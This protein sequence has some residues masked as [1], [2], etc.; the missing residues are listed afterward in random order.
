MSLKR[1]LN[2]LLTFALAFMLLGVSLTPPVLYAAVRPATTHRSALHP[3]AIKAQQPQFLQPTVIPTGN[4]PAG[5]QTA[6]LNNDGRPDLVYTDYGASAT[7]SSTHILLNN[8]DGT[9]TPG[10]TIATAGASIAVAD[11]DR[12]G[13][14]DLEWVWSIQGEGR[15]YFAHGNGDGT[16]APTVLLG[17]FA[18]IGNNLPAL[19]YVTAAPMHDSGFLDLLVEDTANNT[20]FELTADSS[21]TLVRLF[22]I[23]LPDGTG[24]LTT[25]D[26]NGDGHTDLILQGTNAQGISTID[27]YLGSAD[28]IISVP[29]TRIPA[30]NGLR[31]LLLQDVDADGHPDLILESASGHLDIFHGFPDGTFSATSSGG[32]A[33]LNPA[34]GAG[35]HL[36]ALSNNHLYTATPA[37]LSALQLNPDLT[38]TLQGLYNAGPSPA[39]AHSSYVVADF[40]H[41]GTLDIALDSPDGIAILFANLDG[42]LQTSRSYSINQPALSATLGTFSGSGNT[43]AI[44]WASSKLQP[45]QTQTQLLQGS[46]D[47]TFALLASPGASIPGTPTGPILTADFNA[48][49]KLDLVLPTTTGLYLQYGNG[50]GTFAAPTAITAQSGDAI[51]VDQNTLLAASANSTQVLTAHTTTLTAGTSGLIA[52]GD[53][54]HDGQADLLLQNGTT[55]TTY[56]S[57]G[58]GGSISQG[59][60][61]LSQSSGN[62]TPGAP[63]PNVPAGTAVAALIADLDGDGNGDVLLLFGDPLADRAHPTA[64]TASKLVIW[65]GKANGGF[66]NPVSIGLSRS[67]T[68]LAAS[69]IN[70]TGLPDILLTDGYLVAILANQAARSFAQEQHLLAGTSIGSIST[71]DLNRDGTTDLVLSNGTAT[72][73]TGGITVLLNTRIAQTLSATLTA[74]PNATLY[75]AP[76]TITAAVRPMASGPAATGTVTFALDGVALGIIPVAAGTATIAGPTST[77]VGTHTLTAQYSG[78]TTYTGTQLLASHAVTGIPTTVLFTLTTPTT[79]YFGQ[80]VDGFASVTASDNSQLAGTI[81]FYDDTRNICTIPVAANLSCPAAAGTGFTTGQHRLTAVYSG[82]TTHATA[83]S[84]IAIVTI[85]PNTTTATLNASATSIPAGQPLTLAAAVYAAFSTPTG[86]I[87]LFDGQT[88]IGSATLAPNG[89]ANGSATFTTSTLTPGPHT[90]TAAYSATANFNAATSASVTVT[91]TGTA[92]VA[93]V[94]SAIMLSSSANPATT[95]QP[96]TLTAN[97]VAVGTTTTPPTGFVTFSESS[98]SGAIALGSAV[99]SPTGFATFT[100]STLT[101]GTHTITAIYAGDSTTAA[102]Q[103]SPF[104]QIVQAPNLPTAV[105]FILGVGS[106]ALTL[107]TGDETTLAVK[108]SPV[109]GFAQPVQLTCS[110]LP[111]QASCVFTTATIPGGGGTTTLRI[112]TLAP[113]ACGTSASYSQTAANAA[114][115]YAAPLLAGL[116]FAFLPLATKRR[117]RTWKGL[118]ALLAMAGM[119]AISGCGAC[120][121]LGTLPGSYTI[122]ITGTAQNSPQAYA[123]GAPTIAVT[124]QLKITVT[125]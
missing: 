109:N 74:N 13:H 105:S 103:S 84:N 23:H 16:F 42:T 56:L 26:L 61:G 28:G 57:Q 76:F 54:N 25:A 71:A 80:T 51:V 53:I 62:F 18:Q 39:A 30:P 32:T 33:K 59:S 106:N 79:L 115:P 91:I 107:A 118:F 87:T 88:A 44:A 48:D 19:N 36:I 100:T 8:G 21:G 6:D 121:D 96:I 86:A 75:G 94:A 2:S 120:T 29:N 70:A 3:S 12:D 81:T 112:M 92:P 64:A 17:T 68:T 31:S 85:L 10:Q 45:A 73:S 99:L 67:Y 97:V 89:A 65:Y 37:G 111:R 11:F 43:D 119:L 98:Q 24:P 55:W 63:L 46:P 27:I 102:S 101:A 125:P 123:Q 83:T 90:L 34:T 1:I 95:A 5:I 116:C 4:W 22:G 113:R 41:D 7:A 110:N 40:N 38:L 58:S 49:G 20:L 78:D 108:V 47:G 122:G 69:D 15:V 77:A 66:S 117:R 124:Q 72:S 60:G 82:D 104:S 35:G 14:P 52:A 114:L 50:D 9:F 93:P